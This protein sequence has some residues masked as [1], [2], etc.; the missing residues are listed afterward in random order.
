MNDQRDR[1]WSGAVFAL[2]CDDN[3]NYAANA[4]ALEMPLA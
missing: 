4:L 3:L 2:V 1:K